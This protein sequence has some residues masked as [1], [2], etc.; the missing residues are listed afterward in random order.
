MKHIKIKNE[1]LEEQIELLKKIYNIRTDTKLIAHIVDLE[2][3]KHN[4]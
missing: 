1:Q 4:L 3:K 2:M